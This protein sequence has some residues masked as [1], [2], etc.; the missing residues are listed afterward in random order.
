ME[1]TPLLKQYLEIKKNYK[2]ELLF[3]R[4]GDFYELFY[5]DAKIASKELGI[6]LTSKPFGKNIRVPLA[7]VPVKA[8]EGYIKEL[9]KKGYSVAICEQ[10]EEGKDIMKREV[11]EVLTPGTITIPSL[12]EPSQNIYILCVFPSESKFGIAYADITTGEMRTGVLSKEEFFNFVESLKPKEV[13]VP[14]N[15]EL[16][17]YILTPYDPTLYTKE[18]AEERIKE[19]FNVYDL[20]GF[21]LEKNESLIALSHL[22]DYL[23]IK[24]KGGLENLRLKPF[25]KEDVLILDSITVKNLEI[26]ERIHPEEGKS[27]FEILNF[28]R[29]SMGAR[30]LKNTLLFPLKN[31]DKIEERFDAVYELIEKPY[32]RKTIS[33][34]LS[35]FVDFERVL[36]RIVRRKTSA[37]EVKRLGENLIEID[38]LKETLLACE[39]PLLLKIGSYL[40]DL[41]ELG[42]FILNYLKENP[43]NP[44]EGNCIREGVSKELDELR[45]L[46]LNSAKRIRE[47]EERERDRTGIPNLR[48]KYN[49][50]MG[51]FIEITKSYL[52]KVPEDYIRKQTLTQSERYITDELKELESKILSADERIKELENYLFNKLLDKIKEKKDEI[53]DIAEN[54]SLLDLLLCFAEIAIKYNYNRP[55][56]KD[57]KIIYLKNSRH[58][59]VEHT[60]S[61]FIPNDV[62]ITSDKFFLLITGPNMAGKSTF[63][64]QIAL[65]V[66]LAQCGSFVPAEE[67]KIGI[68]DRVFTRI[69]ASD[70]VARGIS[71]FYAEML[72]V[73]Q[74]LNNATEKS[75]ILLDEIGRGTSTYDGL[76]IAWAVSEDIVKRL[77]A[78]TL[79]ATHYHELTALAENYTEIQNLYTLVKEWQGEI[80]FLRKIVP[81][82]MDRS[83]GVYVAK[84]AGVPG[85]VIQRA[86]ELLERLESKR[87]PLKFNKKQLELFERPDP[88]RELL[89]KIDPDE[90]SPK[91]A[92]ELVYEIKKI[93]NKNT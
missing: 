78:R 5:E 48:I 88:L 77:R 20:G 28:T 84:L 89:D 36:S 16:D 23:E 79:F 3:F 51:F 85:H 67:A 72:E 21:G 34:I 74:I 47:I 61:E 32:L 27:L 25:K 39:S 14:Q 2:N 19:F 73:S 9:L 69:G 7:G 62:N 17:G 22:I 76:A 12:L 86:R 46:K 53:L 83:Y 15:Y 11:I 31:K 49:Q 55:E 40:H 1:L 30:L 41:K 44:G 75:L 26:I 93:L 64:R 4:M 8:A 80:I 63:L 56:L 57:E 70:D 60:V 13:L 59:V 42:E 52:D 45:D 87:K 58:P 35:E 65:C 6:T 71:T 43:S 82:S 29:T 91:E 92:L 37:G 54:V 81:G 33:E 10:L 50:V 24:K 18:N 38:N 66:I 68:V 90:L